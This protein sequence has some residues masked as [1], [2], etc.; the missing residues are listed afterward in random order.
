MLKKYFAL[1]AFAVLA[2]CS[3][4]PPSG[5]LTTNKA[6]PVGG[7]LFL[8]P[9]GGN[10]FILVLDGA[11]TGETSYTFLRMVQTSNINGLI[12]TQSSGGDLF[13]A[14]QIGDAIAREGINTAV[15]AMCHSA[16]VDIFI[17]GK[18]RGITPGAVLGLHSASNAEIGYQLDRRYWSKRGL[19][20]I[21]EMVY[22]VPHDKLWLV[23]ARRATELRL[24]TR[25]LN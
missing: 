15:L 14:H 11:I 20:H 23:D 9:L 12:I 17:A 25:V 5:V 4:T 10:E 18:D 24:A 13:A 1:L 16:C 3:S 22:Q 21:N 7:S 2:A 8:E 19:G 6:V